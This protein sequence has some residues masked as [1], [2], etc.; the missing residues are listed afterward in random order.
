[1]LT[2]ATDLND[3]FADGFYGELGRFVISF[4]PPGQTNKASD[5]PVTTPP[6]RAHNILLRAMALRMDK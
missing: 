3:N 2:G 1:M 4:Y 6:T 5:P